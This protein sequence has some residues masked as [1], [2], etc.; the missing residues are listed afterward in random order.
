ML[1]KLFRDVPAGGAFQVPRE[2]RYFEPSEESLDRGWPGRKWAYIRI[3]RTNEALNLFTGFSKTFDP[4]TEV[5]LV[6]DEKI[7]KPCGN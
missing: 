4:E 7:F 1:E 3:G 6:S 5:E 2:T